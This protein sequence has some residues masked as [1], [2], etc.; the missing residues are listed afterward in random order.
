MTDRV[1]QRMR[2]AGPKKILAC[3]GGGILGLMS[4]EILA[5]LEAELRAR[6]GKPGL[7]LV[8]SGFAPATLGLAA[9]AA[10][11]RLLAC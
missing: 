8:L 10:A 11:G 2:S 6:T 3:D 1:L 9:R 7:V 4:V 5:K